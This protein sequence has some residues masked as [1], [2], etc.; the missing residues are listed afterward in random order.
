MFEV[1]IIYVYFQKLS[2]HW[3]V[4]RLVCVDKVFVYSY[5]QSSNSVAVVQELS[6]PALK[7]S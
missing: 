4:L 1:E 6:L 3:S 5:T 2:N 7:N